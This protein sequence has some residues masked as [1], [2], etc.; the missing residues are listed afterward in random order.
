MSANSLGLFQ[1]G[2][3]QYGLGAEDLDPKKLAVFIEVEN[4]FAAA[5]DFVNVLPNSL[6]S[7]YSR[8]DVEVSRIRRPVIG[9]SPQFLHGARIGQ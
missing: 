8:R 3:A 1:V 5:V 7:F 9:A 2:R 4:D 6:P